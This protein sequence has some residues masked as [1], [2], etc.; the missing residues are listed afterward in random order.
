M[1]NLIEEMYMCTIESRGHM[2]EIAS[3]TIQKTLK[4]L[5]GT[6][7]WSEPELHVGEGTLRQLPRLL[8]EKQLKKVLIVTDKGIIQ[9]GLLEQFIMNLDEQGMTYRVFDGIEPNPTIE[10]CEEIAIHFNS[11]H[12]DA[13]IAVGG[14]SVLDAAKAA[15]IIIT[16][17]EKPLSA[18]RGLLKVWKKTPYTVMV[19]TTA[20]TGSEGTIA[21]VLSSAAGNEKY[22]IMDNVLTPDLAVLDSDLIQ[23]LPKSLIAGPGMDALTHAVEAYIGQS[24]TAETK[25]HA[26]ATVK[27]MSENLKKVY[28]G[29][30]DAE[31]RENLLLASYYG[32]RAFTRAYVGYVHAISHALTAYYNLP[33]G[34][35][36]ATVLP[37]VL[38]LF[39]ENIA[40]ALAELAVE[41]GIENPEGS[42]VENAKRFIKWVDEMNESM[43]IAK[44]IP[45]IKE[46]DLD[47]LT[48]HAAKEAHPLYPVPIIFTRDDIKEAYR[49]VKGE[50]E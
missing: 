43:G 11:L 24:N 47:G 16:Q 8:K 27:L 25:E 33:H 41:A 21:S 29:E 26:K 37:H 10:M 42:A 31:A 2:N 40:D 1:L 49:I 44:H 19:P 30:A 38:R 45:E 22:A 17:P 12:A 14:G 48:E 34:S 15:G 28:D 46:T 9:A 4:A 5:S 18:F 7:D 20:G 50:I 3:R 32:G 13:I 39:G 35:T 23:T 36:N 6:L